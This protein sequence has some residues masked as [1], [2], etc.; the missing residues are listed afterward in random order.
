MWLTGQVL[1]FLWRAQA[2]FHVNQVSEAYFHKVEDKYLHPFFSYLCI[3][4]F[5]DK[6]IFFKGSCQIYVIYLFS[7]VGYNEI[8]EAI[9]LIAF[10]IFL[11]IKLSAYTFI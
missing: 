6:V 1:P 8:Q 10:Q 7:K 9:Y 2:I 5:D 11:N 4:N 3:T